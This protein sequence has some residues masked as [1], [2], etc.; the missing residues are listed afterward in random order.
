M[1]RLGCRSC[2]CF[3]IPWLVR[4]PLKSPG[5]CRRGVGRSV[6]RP[7]STSAGGFVFIPREKAIGLPAMLEKNASR[8]VD[9]DT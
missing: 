3:V 4:F 2:K 6:V 7:G 9:V 8:G 1:Q 5:A